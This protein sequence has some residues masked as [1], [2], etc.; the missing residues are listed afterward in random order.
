M[1]NE[2]TL[3]IEETLNLLDNSITD[4][5]TIRQI[6]LLSLDN[7]KSTREIKNKLIDKIKSGYEYCGLYPYV[8][9]SFNESDYSGGLCKYQK[10]FDNNQQLINKMLTDSLLPLRNFNK[11]NKIS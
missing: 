11:N 3:N 10:E 2:I 4:P 9:G 1:T 7:T 8:M 5:E 6:A